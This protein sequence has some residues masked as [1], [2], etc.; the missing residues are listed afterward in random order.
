M[1]SRPTRGEEVSRARRDLDC[2]RRFRARVTGAGQ[3][4]AERLAATGVR[5][6]VVDE[7]TPRCCMTTGISALVAGAGFASLRAPV[8]M[9]TAPHTPVPFSDALGVALA[10]GAVG[11]R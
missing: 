11:Q 9:V 3:V 8:E 5:L 2:L 10:R 4:S 1:F 7:A 6:V